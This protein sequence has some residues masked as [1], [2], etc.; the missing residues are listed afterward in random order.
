MHKLL[1]IYFIVINI[2]AFIIFAFDK[3]MATQNRRRVSEKKLH[4]FSM[5]GGFVGSSLSMML[6]R[7]KTVKSSFLNKHITIIVLW[8][9]WIFIYFTQIDELNFL[10]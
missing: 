5:L 6:F 9:I 2:M 1:V 7:H 10:L 4:F 8:I 3:L